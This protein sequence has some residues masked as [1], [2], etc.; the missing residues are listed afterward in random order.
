[1]SPR[2]RWWTRWSRS[3]VDLAIWWG[4]W[5][6]SSYPGRIPPWPPRRCPP[7]LS[8]MRALG[9]DDPR[10]TPRESSG[11][12]PLVVA[13]MGVGR[14]AGPGCADGERAAPATSRTK[15]Q[16]GRGYDDDDEHFRLDGLAS[17]SSERYRVGKGCRPCPPA[18]ET[19]CGRDGHNQPRGG[20][21]R[22]TRAT[23]LVQPPPPPPS[24]PPYHSRSRKLSV[25]RARAGLL[26]AVPIPVP[27]PARRRRR[28]PRRRRCQWQ[29]P[30]RVARTGA[31]S[32]AGE[33]SVAGSSRLAIRSAS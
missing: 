23:S 17:V 6:R 16:G 25:G 11:I 19:W 27:V 1:M 18:G 30:Q 20:P 3:D 26:G 7:G 28:R 29:R 33:L 22:P 5:G 2:R 15:G 4:R 8:P 12:H 14:P 21:S 13:A 10:A 9:T 31:T 32:D 24:S